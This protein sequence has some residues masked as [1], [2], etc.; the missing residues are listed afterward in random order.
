MLHVSNTLR[1]EVR[2]NQG[3]NCCG[4][5][6]PLQ[7]QEVVP[8]AVEIL[9]GLMQLHAMHILHLD[10][11]PGNVLLDDHGLAY[12]SDFGI[13]HALSTLEALPAVSIAAGT[14]HYM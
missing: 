12:L 10:L 3:T 5:A 4:A 9:E 13:S 14:P 11:K 2:K 8:M 1:A 7:L 6:G